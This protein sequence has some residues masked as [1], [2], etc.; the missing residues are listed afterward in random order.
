MLR[1]KKGKMLEVTR[2][3]T[4]TEERWTLR[5][6]LV[7][8]S[9]NELRA[10]WMKAHRGAEGRTCLVVLNEVISIDESGERVLRTMCNQGAQLVASSMDMKRLLERLKSIAQEVRPWVHKQYN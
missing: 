9:V 10:N 1:T 5:G 8:P 4:A 2:T 3:E 7:W 6:R